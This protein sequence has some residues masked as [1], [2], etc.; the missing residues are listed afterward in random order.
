MQINKQICGKQ[1]YG[2]QDQR[3]RRRCTD[4]TDHYFEKGYR[5]RHDFV[6]ATGKLGKEYAER[7]IGDA[8]RQQGQHDQ[9]RNDEHCI[10]Y[11]FNLFDAGA[12]GSTEH[13][14]VKR[15]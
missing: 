2:T 13:N 4:I 1:D 12:D 10:R 3:F 5:C 15:S 6:N 7:R 9:P 14:E 8:L 11:P